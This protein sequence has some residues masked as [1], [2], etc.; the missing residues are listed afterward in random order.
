MY[1]SVTRS[2]LLSS[3]LN[4]RTKDEKMAPINIILFSFLIFD[5]RVYCTQCT[6]HTRTSLHAYLSSLKPCR[7]FIWWENC[8]NNKYFFL[9]CKN[10]SWEL[11]PNCHYF[12]FSWEI[13]IWL[14]RE[15]THHSLTSAPAYLGCLRAPCRCL[16]D[17]VSSSSFAK[18]VFLSPI[19]SFFVLIFS[20]VLV[21]STNTSINAS[22]GDDIGEIRCWLYNALRAQCASSNNVDGKKLKQSYLW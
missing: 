9:N 11:G 19:K 8:W 12:V 15:Y 21:S 14:T 1:V 20:F 3:K 10:R 13:L 5:V 7:Q 16:L 2:L 4:A 17:K 6:R 18:M 22:S